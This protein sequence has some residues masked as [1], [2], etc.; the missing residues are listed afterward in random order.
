[1]PIS[2]PNLSLHVKSVGI[3]RSLLQEEKREMSNKDA[4]GGG[5]GVSVNYM[6]Y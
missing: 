6:S 4:G 2:F 1:M 3:L 5:A